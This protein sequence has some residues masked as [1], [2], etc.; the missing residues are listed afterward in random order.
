[1]VD[2]DVARDLFKAFPNGIINYHLEFVADPN[3][4]VNSYFGLE[5]C[6][7]RMDVTVKVLSFLS[8]EAFKSQHF[9]AEW[10]NRQV[11]RYHLQGINRFCGTA[12]TEAE[13]EM[14]YTLFGNG[15][16]R[17]ECLAFIQDEFDVRM[18]ERMMVNAV[19]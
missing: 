2:K 9:N 14:V 7:H 16:R 17:T 19:D 4:R 18:L 10:R 15:L 5:N 3:P 6:C 8:R 12:F 11:W 13:I 1:M